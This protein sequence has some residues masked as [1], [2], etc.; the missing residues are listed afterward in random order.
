MQEV[1]KEIFSAEV[2][3]RTG[4]VWGLDSEG[5]VNGSYRPS[6]HPGVSVRLSPC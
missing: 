6:G 1:N 4:E 3:D 2:V 5:E